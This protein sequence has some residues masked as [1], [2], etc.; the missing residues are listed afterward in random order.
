MV[1]LWVPPHHPVEGNKLEDRKILRSEHSLKKVL[2]IFSEVTIKEIITVHAFKKRAGELRISCKY[3]TV[4]V[5]TKQSL[6]LFHQY[7]TS[8]LVFLGGGAVYLNI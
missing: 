8:R 1:L 4:A 7:I 6:K 3:S 2:L 5:L